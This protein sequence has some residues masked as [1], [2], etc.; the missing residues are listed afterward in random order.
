ML[1]EQEFSFQ[2]SQKELLINLHS[3]GQVNESKDITLKYFENNIQSTAEENSAQNTLNLDDIR[4]DLVF[5]KYKDIYI[6][7]ISLQD[8]HKR[9]KFGLNK[10]NENCFYIGQWKNNMKH[11]IG[12][13]KIN[14]NQMYIGGFEFN[15]FNGFGLLYYK[16]TSTI[17][18]GNFTKGRFE[19][20][21]YYNITDDIFYRGSIVNNKKNDHF[22]TF[23]DVS[24]GNMFIGEI[25]DD[26]FTK[27]Y[28]GLC[29][30]KEE[31]GGEGNEEEMEAEGVEGNSED[32][33][34]VNFNVHKLF[35]FEGPGGRVTKFIH[36][37]QFTGD[38]FNQMGEVMNTI[39]QADYN[40]RDQSENILEYFKFLEE[41]QNKVEYTQYIEKYC[42]ID[43]NYS[44]EYEFSYRFEDFCQRFKMGQKDLNLEE[45][46][47]ILDNPGVEGAE[48]S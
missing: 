29:E 31:K 39:F 24:K 5:I 44:I 47:E 33:V 9:E 6:G 19:K 42:P 17:F 18:C 10:Y 8:F 37:Q 27:G 20:G 26:I 15:Q 21:I 3:K 13:I 45:Y 2:Q 30:L 4:N 7:G 48:E 25:I 28:V 38:F 14:S 1:Y 34:V 46:E 22:C 23:F 11:G 43:N 36:H 40:L 12:F 41:I 32:D 35:Y 16:D